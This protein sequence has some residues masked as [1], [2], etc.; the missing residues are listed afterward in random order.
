MDLI[1]PIRT[2]TERGH[3]Y[4]LTVVDYAS[5]YS[6]DVAVKKITSEVVADALVSIYSRVGVPKYVLTDLG[7]QIVSHVMKEVHEEAPQESLGFS[8]IDF[9]YGRTVRGLMMILRE[10]W[11]KEATTPEVETTYHYVL[12][13]RNRLQ[14]TCTLAQA[15]LAK[16][17]VRYKRYYDRKA[18]YRKFQPGDKV[19]VLLPTDHNKL[20]MQWQGPM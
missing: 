12:D 7:T 17:K 10:L 3:R 2:A 15:E 19:L 5:R 16:A 8:S 1:G 13:L 14:E 18:R 6:E 9:I 11:T 20:L 4:I